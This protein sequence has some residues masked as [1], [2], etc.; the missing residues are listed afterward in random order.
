M[1]LQIKSYLWQ[2]IEMLSLLHWLLLNFKIQAPQQKI[3]NYD[4][5]SCLTLHTC[6][7]Q[8][9]RRGKVKSKQVF[10]LGRPTSAFLIAWQVCVAVA[11]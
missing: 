9:S 8:S 5:F 2:N 1:L 7:V 6:H 3:S 4:K 10:L 11:Y